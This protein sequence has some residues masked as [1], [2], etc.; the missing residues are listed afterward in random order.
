MLMRLHCDGPLTLVDTFYTRPEQ[1]RDLGT[2]AD[3][4]LEA[5]FARTGAVIHSGPEPQAYYD[6]RTDHIHM[7]PIETFLSART[8]YG[9][10]GHELCHW[11]GAEQR[12]DRFKRF[13]NR[14]AYAFEELVAEIGACMLGVKIGMEPEFDQSASYVEGWLAAM[15]GDNR[16]IFRAASEAQKAVDFILAQAGWSDTEQAA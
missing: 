6:L 8:F 5:F 11:T 3:P 1:P 13:S 9:T 12:L 4:E 10:L 7:P 16:A 15:K 2:S 14:T